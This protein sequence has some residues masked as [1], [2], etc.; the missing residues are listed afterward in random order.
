MS[1]R[2]DGGSD[3]L[4]EYWWLLLVAVLFGGGWLTL[5]SPSGTGSEAVSV[6]R[7]ETA[8]EQ[9]LNSLDSTENPQ[10]A[11]GSPGAGPAMPAAKAAVATLKG[12]GSQSGSLYQAPDGAAGSPIPEGAAALIDAAAKGQTAGG[13]ISLAQAL[14]GVAASATKAP[15][16][17][18]GGA[19]AHSGFSKPRA[20]FGQVGESRMGGGAGT[21]TG[22]VSVDKAFGTGGNPGLNLAPGL[23]GAAAD[24]KGKLA[25]AMQGGAGVEGLKAARKASLDALKSGD[26]AASGRGRQSFDGGGSGKTAFQQLSSAGSSAGV[27]G[28]GGV[29]ANLKANDPSKLDVKKFEPPPMGKEAEK[30]D[31]SNKEYMQ[32]QM[33]MM[34]LGIAMTGILGPAAGGMGM[35]MFQSMGGNPPPPGSSGAN[36]PITVK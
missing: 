13:G 9:S 6:A 34:M 29:P 18:W 36:R 24:A 22:L 17:G 32:Q 28:D 30:K 2:A 4:K 1:S 20:A 21:S 5:S 16:N 27:S 10:G 15:D 35:M 11:P 8:N 33:M 26:E 31:A 19:S 3:L 12:A 25:G 23:A 14:R 7:F